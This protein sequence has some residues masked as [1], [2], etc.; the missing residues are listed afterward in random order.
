M[1]KPKKIQLLSHL[2]L[3][4]SNK[5]KKIFK[6]IIHKSKSNLL[7]QKSLELWLE[8]EA[9]KHLL[10]LRIQELWAETNYMI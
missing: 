10:I 6:N 7:K 1:K 2:S 8:R 5:Y 3:N 9:L 4:H